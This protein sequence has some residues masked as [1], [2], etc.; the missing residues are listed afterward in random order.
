MSLENKAGIA[1]LEREFEAELTENIL[2]F[3]LEHG[4]DPESGGII[5]SLDRRGAVL[6][7]DKSVWFQGRAAWTFATAYAEV[8][9]RPEYL[10]ASRS[11]LD[12]IEAHCF[13]SDGRMF[14]RVTRDGRPVIKRI[15]YVFSEAFAAMGMAA[16]ARARRWLRNTRER[17][18]KSS[19]ASARSSPPPA[20]SSPSSTPRRG[21]RRASPSP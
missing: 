5:T 12:F 20:S 7:T 9:Q 2:P 21:L 14:F 3:W 13:D 8:A 10:A 4:M 11:C 15:R 19:T 17:P 1:A 6:D 16:Y 18:G